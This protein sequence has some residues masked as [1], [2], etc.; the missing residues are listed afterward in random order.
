MAKLRC[1][2]NAV[3]LLTVEY[4]ISKREKTCCRGNIIL[5]TNGCTV[6]CLSYTPVVMGLKKTEFHVM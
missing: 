1:F 2:L 3:I 5:H 6:R 4:Q